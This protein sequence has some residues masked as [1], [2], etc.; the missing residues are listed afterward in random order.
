M[1]VST[2]ISQ[3]DQAVADQRLVLLAVGGVVW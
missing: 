1:S 2:M 3:W